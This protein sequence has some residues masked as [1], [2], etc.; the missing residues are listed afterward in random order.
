MCTLGCHGPGWYSPSVG[1]GCPTPGGRE[2]RSLRCQLCHP[3][4]RPQ[5]HSVLELPDTVWPAPL[6]MMVQSAEPL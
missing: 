3:E 2:D 6:T 1:S 5:W 4:P